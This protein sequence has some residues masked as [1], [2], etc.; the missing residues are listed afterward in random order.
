MTAREHYSKE[1]S[2]T[3]FFLV[4]ISTSVSVPDDKWLSTLESTHWLDYIR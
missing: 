1:T 4:D 2:Q 3:T